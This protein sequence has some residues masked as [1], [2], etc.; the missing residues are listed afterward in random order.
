MAMIIVNSS[1]TVKAVRMIELSTSCP[2]SR[3]EEGQS[4]RVH[5]PAESASNKEPF[6]K[7]NPVNCVFIPVV[8]TVSNV[9]F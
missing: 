8:R 1:I 5:M 2:H 4:K 3:Q 6:W 7:P 9:Y